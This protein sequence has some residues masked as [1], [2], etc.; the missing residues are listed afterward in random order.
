MLNEG[1]NVFRDKEGKPATQR[2]KLEDIPATVRWLESVTGLDLTGDERDE[3]GVPVRWLGSTGRRPDSGDIDLAVTD[4]AKDQLYQRLVTW[5]KKNG[6]DPSDW[7]KRGSEVHLRTPIAGDA[8]RGFVQT[9]FNFYSDPALSKWAQFYM[10]GTSDGYKGM[11]RNVLLSSLAKPFGVKIGGNGM[12]DRAT[13][14]PVRGGLDPDLVARM[15][16][17]PGH[18]RQDLR[19]VESIYA[20][21]DSDPQR[22]AKLADF[23]AFLDR[24]GLSEP[25]TAVTESDVHFMARLRDRIVNQ[26]M[27]PLVEQGQ[28]TGRKDPRIPHPEDA[29]FLGGSAAALQQLAALEYAAKQPE[30]ITI[31]WDGKPALIWGRMPNGHL[32]VMDKYMFDAGFAAQ[33]PEDWK[34]YDQQKVTGQPRPDVYPKI[35]AI[36][37]GL[38]RATTGPGFYWGDLLWAGRLQPQQGQY[39]FQPNTVRYTIPA[40]SATGKLISDT[41][42]GIVVH[43]KF[44]N[45]GDKT[46]QVWDGSGLENVK[47][48]VAILG[49]TLGTRFQIRR[50]DLGAARAAIKKYGSAVDEFLA[51]LPTS[52]RQKLQTF[53]NQR[54][55]GGTTFQLANWLKTNTS[56]RQ[57]QE[58]VVGNP[59]TDG[60]YDAKSGNLP[61]KLFALDAQNKLVPSAAYEGITEIWNA[62]YDVKTAMA[63]QLEQ[64]I[65]GLGQETA[66]QSQGEGFV[67]NTPHGLVKLVNRGVF[68]AANRLANPPRR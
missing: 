28:T 65:Q 52:V 3:Q 17:G 55:T 7:V 42:G 57:Y 1:G 64:Q 20:A 54:I 38:D 41:T 5:V 11:H 9:D 50:P 26:G 45:L 49:P 15:I 18:T 66:G 36:W 4:V 22:D 30:N 8:D 47:G 40:D 19:T 10:G 61:G 33:S 14:E 56:G 12:I 39:V 13:N 51:G 37:P 46:A 35:R 48:G 6:Q 2:I 34:R 32:A 21:L 58:M 16:L 67:V 68:G 29:V 24:E 23:R 25:D 27:Q 43:Q 63:Q 62:V 31:K 60:S 59:R 53:F 44:D